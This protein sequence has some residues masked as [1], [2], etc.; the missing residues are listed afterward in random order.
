MNTTITAEL[1][2]T[3]I[4][5]GS[6]RPEQTGIT[7]GAHGWE[8]ETDPTGLDEHLTPITV[9]GVYAYTDG[10]E[11]DDDDLAALASAADYQ[12]QREDGA[13]LPPGE[14]IT[15]QVVTHLRTDYGDVVADWEA[16]FWINVDAAQLLVQGSPV[17]GITES[18]YRSGGG[19]WL[20]HR[21]SDWVKETATSWWE[22]GIAE[23]VKIAYLAQAGQIAD[24]DTLPGTIAAA[25]HARALLDAVAPTGAAVSLEEATEIARG[26]GALATLL[27]ER[28]S[29]DLRARRA[30][31]A[32]VVI[33]GCDGNQ[34][35][36]AQVMGIH[37]GTLNDLIN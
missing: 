5:R 16:A 21:E 10:A 27:R 11:P 35:E 13:T 20:I 17:G 7:L 28:V 4:N 23:A 29:S 30:D 1:I 14:G 22:I 19:R 37:R 3:L 6:S 31:A 12:I 9:E 8:A 32:R 2:H 24:E 34:S 26:A 33:K 15:A 18:L 36:A 25:R